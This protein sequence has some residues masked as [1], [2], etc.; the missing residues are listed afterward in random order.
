MSL[1][2]FLFE[3]DGI[4]KEHRTDGEVTIHVLTGSLAVRVT[5]GEVQLGPGDLLSLAAGQTH[6]VRANDA[7]EML[8]TVCR[9]AET[10]T[11]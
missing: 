6:S 5:N 3:K 10:D 1:I 8:L 7:S 2:L 9:A 11:D 4:L